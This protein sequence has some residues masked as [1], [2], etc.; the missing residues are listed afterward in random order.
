MRY[1]LIGRTTWLSRPAATLRVGTAR[2]AERP[3]SDFDTGGAENQAA[4]RAAG[5]AE[6]G[7]AG[8]IA[9][10]TRRRTP[11]VDLLRFGAL[12]ADGAVAGGDV[13]G[14]PPATDIEVQFP[15]P[16]ADQVRGDWEI[17]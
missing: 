3:G 15:G 8:R 5:P 12:Q 9:C 10:P 11:R 16:V 2:A 7:S 14:R 6:S 1:A 13:N 4:R 17:G